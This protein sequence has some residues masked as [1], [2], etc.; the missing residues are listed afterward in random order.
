[1]PYPVE[2]ISFC[3]Y[4]DARLGHEL[5]VCRLAWTDWAKL[6]ELGLDGVQA[7]TQFGV[8]VTVAFNE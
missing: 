7:L 5:V 1:M 8:T 2:Q 3:Y 6:V 4:A